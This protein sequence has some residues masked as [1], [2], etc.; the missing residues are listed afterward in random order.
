MVLSLFSG[1]G[2]YGLQ[3]IPEVGIT[4]RGHD[5]DALRFV[6]TACAKRPMFCSATQPPAMHPWNAELDT[7]GT[8]TERG[9]CY[10]NVG[11]SSC[12]LAT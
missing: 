11:V 8:P 12:D 10:N 1:C 9:S 6:L 4:E 7:P 5:C 3:K 2:A